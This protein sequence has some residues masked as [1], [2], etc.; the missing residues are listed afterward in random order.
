VRASHNVARRAKDL[1]PSLRSHIARDFDVDLTDSSLVLALL[2]AADRVLFESSSLREQ[3]Q[4]AL[5]ILSDVDAARQSLSAERALALLD[6]LQLLVGMQVA[7]RGLAAG[8]LSATHEWLLRALGIAYGGD[9]E[10][11][12]PIDAI[13]LYRRHSTDDLRADAAEIAAA[14]MAVLFA[15]AWRSGDHRDLATLFFQPSLELLDA[16]SRLH[17]SV[18]PN[19]DVGIQLLVH[20]MQW[21]VDYA[22]SAAADARWR[23]LHAVASGTVS[24]S[25]ERLA[26]LC[27]AC[28][29]PLEGEQHQ[30]QQAEAALARWGSELHAQER[31]QLLLSAAGGRV[32]RVLEYM[33]ALLN[34]LAEV[35]AAVDHRSSR[36]SERLFHQGQSFRMLGP[37]VRPLAEAGKVISAVKL[38]TGW[39]ADPDHPQPVE[40]PLL[41][42][43]TH[44]VGTL[45]ATEGRTAPQLG[46]TH[47]DMLELTKAINRF[48]R[49]TL[50]FRDPR[51]DAEPVTGVPGLPDGN[52]ADEYAKAAIAHLRIDALAALNVRPETLVVA[53][54]L[55]IPLQALLLRELDWVPTVSVSYRAPD[56]DRPLLRVALLEDVRMETALW[57]VDL[58]SA[59]MAGI[60]ATVVRE[61]ASFKAFGKYYED[62]SID[63]L[64]LASHAQFEHLRPEQSAIMLGNDCVG[65]D[66]LAALREPKSEG[67]RLIVLNTCD[68][69]MSAPLGGLMG[70]GLGPS[71][72]SPHQAVVS[73]LWA[74]WSIV[75]ACFGVGLAASL[76]HGSS[77][78]AAYAD[79]TRL[80]IAGRKDLVECLEKYGAAA[81]PLR[82][83]VEMTDI[84]YDSVES[85]GSPTLLS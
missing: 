82:N 12:I 18:G 13:H 29:A 3:E 67:R 44:P 78:A 39:V 64:W 8:D 75:A 62:P 25:A 77:F 7:T 60:G 14:W 19:S 65:L 66:A 85:W 40:A 58:V 69:G 70:F 1:F 59:L 57:E 48:L 15:H 31:L 38:L 83:S 36:V 26:S 4:T 46:S 22:P 74:T 11:E 42:L 37:A 10:Y 17:P 33:P 73:H 61:P 6:H 5:A 55:P 76:A 43:L 34:E 81:S 41:A 45:W 28:T 23:L 49:T 71:I 35:R 51:F 84:P 24:E 47:D 2:E 72:A 50:L 52:Y 32:E 9:D 30:E 79:A 53:P 21:A 27:L 54:A 68:A 80:L 63:L 16:G 20:R 56:R